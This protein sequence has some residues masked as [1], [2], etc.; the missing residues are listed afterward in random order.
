MPLQKELDPHMGF[1]K[2]FRQHRRSAEVSQR[3][4]SANV[5]YAQPTISRREKHGGIVPSRIEVIQVAAKLELS[6]EDREEL[7]S[8]AG[9]TWSA[10]F[11]REITRHIAPEL[12]NGE[13]PTLP[14]PRVILIMERS[15]SVL[16]QS[17]ST[18]MS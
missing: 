10:E 1:W 2:M 3:E 18:K 14:K 12:V 7:L 17:D 4:L 5:V 8:A 13:E 6:I 9:Y 16:Q 15:L 11:W